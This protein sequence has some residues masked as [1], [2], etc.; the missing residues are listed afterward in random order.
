MTCPPPAPKK[1]L[2]T[3]SGSLRVWLDLYVRYLES[4]SWR[5]AAF[6]PA[7]HFCSPLS[8]PSKWSA[9]FFPRVKGLKYQTV[10]CHLPVAMTEAIKMAGI[11][12]CTSVPSYKASR[13]LHST[14]SISLSFLASELQYPGEIPLHYISWGLNASS[15]SK[16]ESIMGVFNTFLLPK[17]GIYFKKLPNRFP[18]RWAHCWDIPKWH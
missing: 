8:A 4:P 13:S 6:S 17:A 18:F 1:N 14:A 10:L 16:S 11:K 9:S 5:S 12:D 15:P 2:Q 7:L 3:H